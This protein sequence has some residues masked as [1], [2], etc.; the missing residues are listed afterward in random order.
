MWEHPLHFPLATWT[1]LTTWGDRLWPELIGIL[2]WQDI[3]LG[4]WTYFV[5]TGLLLVVPLQSLKLDD[6][7]RARVAIITGVAVLAYVI[8]VYLIFFLTYTP[9]NID[10]VRG[11][12]GRYFVIA[13]P[14]T[15]IFFAS[16]FN[17][18]LPRRVLATTAISGSLLSGIASFQALLGAHWSAP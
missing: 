6:A 17:I 9:L 18:D 16:M 7:V 5:L 10:H 14:M 2:G 15:A 4:P 1:A 12:Q 11:V 3:P 13:L 8:T